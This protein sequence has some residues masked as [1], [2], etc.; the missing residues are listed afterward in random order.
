MAAAGK[1]LAVAYLVSCAF[2]SVVAGFIGALLSCEYDCAR[3]SPLWL[4]PWTWGDSY[5]FPE[6]TIM[7]V[8]GFLVAS[9]F[10]AFIFDRYWWPAAGSLAI[11]LILMSYPFFGGLTQEGRAK[12]AFGPLFAL[13]AL[14]ARPRR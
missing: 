1:L 7:G 5:V 6:A 2:I 10:V 11:S 14:L 12:L 3:R 8:L 9:F 4:Q 13:S